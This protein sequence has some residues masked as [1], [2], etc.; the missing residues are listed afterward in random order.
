MEGFDCGGFNFLN[1]LAH[2]VIT[3]EYS[4][5]KGYCIS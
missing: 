1:E 2:K 4:R 5:R 3:R